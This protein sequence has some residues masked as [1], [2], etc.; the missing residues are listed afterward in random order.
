MKIH[1]YQTRHLFVDDDCVGKL[2]T[3]T[4]TVRLFEPFEH[5]EKA[6]LGWLRSAHGFFAKLAQ[7]DEARAAVSAPPVEFPDDIR[8]EM[9]PRLGDLT[10]AAVEF[11]REHWSKEEFERRYRGRV[12][13][14]GV[15]DAPPAAEAGGKVVELPA[16]PVKKLSD[17]EQARKMLELAGPYQGAFEK[18]LENQFTIQAAGCLGVSAESWSDAAAD[19]LEA[20]EYA[21]L[22]KKPNEPAEGIDLAAPVVEEEEAAPVMVHEKPAAKKRGRPKKEE[23]TTVPTAPAGPLKELEESNDAAIGGEE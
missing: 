9:D 16:A 20:I 1:M 11:A 5:F 19:L 13:G 18:N 6:V 12:S 21:A 7:G 23:D 15:F 2:C 4:K 22:T 10:P 8:E 17:E 3:K 14:V